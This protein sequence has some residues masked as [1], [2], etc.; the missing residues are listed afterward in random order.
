MISKQLLFHAPES[1]ISTATVRK[2]LVTASIDG[3]GYATHLSRNS[4]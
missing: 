2:V 4:L 3:D 1:V